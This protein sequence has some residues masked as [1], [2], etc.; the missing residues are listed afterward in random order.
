MIDLGNIE[1]VISGVLGDLD[2]TMDEAID[3][4]IESQLDEADAVMDQIIVGGGD[5]DLYLTGASTVIKAGFVAD[6]F[7]DMLKVHKMTRC[8]MGEFGELRGS[9]WII[10]FN[11]G[12]MVDWFLR[13]M[14]DYVGG[15]V[16]SFAANTTFMTEL[17][18]RSLMMLLPEAQR[19]LMWIAMRDLCLAPVG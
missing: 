7:S 8:I 4:T 11:E 14:P 1:D 15:V 9:A 16:K 5:L 10:A 3:G 2:E 17:E 19:D 12:S 13:N 6:T 18:V